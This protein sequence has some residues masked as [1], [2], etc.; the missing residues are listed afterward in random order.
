M[1]GRWWVHG[2]MHPDTGICLH[3]HVL[4]S[5]QCPDAGCF[6]SHEGEFYWNWKHI[7]SLR[8][9]VLVEDTIGEMEL[10][11]LDV[12][13]LMFWTCV[14]FS[15]VMNC[16]AHYWYYRIWVEWAVEALQSLGAERRKKWYGTSVCLNTNVFSCII[17]DPGWPGEFY[18]RAQPEWCIELRSYWMKSKPQFVGIGMQLL[19]L[20]R[21]QGSCIDCY[22]W[23][24]MRW[25]ARKSLW[26]SKQPLQL[27]ARLVS[28]RTGSDRK[29]YWTKLEA[30]VQNLPW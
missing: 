28:T 6:S 7:T 1:L 3:P 23:S 11:P 18:C 26:S 24:L 27:Q 14:T 2:S 15:D 19:C 13:C 5:K 29:G 30:V 16:S 25:R 21:T 12:W 4:A 22:T 17:A 10:L 20:W 8:P 9:I